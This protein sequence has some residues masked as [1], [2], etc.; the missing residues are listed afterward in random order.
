MPAGVALVT[1]PFCRACGWDFVAINTG[2]DSIF[3]SCVDELFNS[4][5]GVGPP[6]DLVATLG[7]D[8]V[9]FTW[10]AGTDTDD[11]QYQINGAAFVFD[12]NATSPYTVAAP[13]VASVSLQVRTVLNGIPGPW[14]APAVASSGQS[15]PTLLTATGISGFVDFAFTA[16]PGADSTT[17]VYTVDAGP[18]NTVLGVVTGVSIAGATGEVISGT[19]ASVQAGVTGVASAPAAD[20]VLA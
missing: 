18:D 17:L 11:V 2:D 10:T 16:D 5:G 9:V 20:T 12:D 14:S 13:A 1:T 8:E 6:A 3:D 19:V 15:P 7:T 4:Q